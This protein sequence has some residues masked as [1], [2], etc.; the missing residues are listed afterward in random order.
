MERTYKAGHDNW[1]YLADVTL[2]LRKMI[3]ELQSKNYE[4]EQRVWDLEGHTI[5][6]TLEKTQSMLNDWAGKTASKPIPPELLKS[7]RKKY[8]VD[9]NESTVSGASKQVGDE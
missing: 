9:Q 6:E 5:E 1:K 7:L 8:G 3:S 4:L 2:R